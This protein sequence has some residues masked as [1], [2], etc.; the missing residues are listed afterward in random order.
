MTI[1]KNDGD[2]TPKVISISHYHRMCKPWILLPFGIYYNRELQSARKGDILLFSDGK[3]RE[4]EYITPV[5]IQSSFTDYFCYKTYRSK[6][7]NIIE[8]WNGN[9]IMEGHTPEVID[10]ERCLLIFLKEQD[11]E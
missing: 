9:A 5:K 2:S 11:N 8:R 3:R 4:I 7:R 6:L 1:M 10:K